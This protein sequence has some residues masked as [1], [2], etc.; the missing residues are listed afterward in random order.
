MT[1]LENSPRLASISNVTFFNFRFQPAENTHQ[2]NVNLCWK[3]LVHHCV[4]VFKYVNAIIEFK[5]DTRRISD[6]HSYNTGG[7]SNFY[8]SGARLNYGNQGL[9]YQRITE[10]KSLD[11]LIRN[12]L[13]L[14]F[15]KQALKTAVILLKTLILYSSTFNILHYFK[16]TFFGKVSLNKPF[17]MWAPWLN[18]IIIIIIVI[19]QYLRTLYCCHLVNANI[20]HNFLL[21]WSF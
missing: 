16:K 13:S 17:V 7:K 3:S 9:F 19:M 6:I 11:K 8:L 15:F 2:K 5:F 1:A 10:W 18:I 12:M 21:K 20:V 4:F 14:L